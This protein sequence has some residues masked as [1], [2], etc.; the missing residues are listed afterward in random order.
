MLRACII[1]FG[2]S[3][4]TYL[5]LAEF[6]YN[7]SYHSSIQM[8]PYQALYSRKFRSPACWHEIGEKRLVKENDLSRITG[9]ELIQETS[10]KIRLIRKN[11]LTAQ[12][13]QKSYADP[14][15]KHIEFSVG[16]RVML[17]VSPWKGV[18]RFGRKGKLA[19]RFV[20]PFT[21]IERVGPVAYKLELP[22]EL[23]KVHPVFHISNLKRVLAPGSVSIPLEDIEVDE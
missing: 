16:D 15:R 4:D 23:N 7:N 11:L 2:G 13:R 18:V 19:P 12:S 3:W 21:I 17:K 6:S 1:D 10:D 9:P 22:S 14:K 5:P 20:G 8:P